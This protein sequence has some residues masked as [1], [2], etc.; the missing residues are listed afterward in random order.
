MPKA[1]WISR[2]W[3]SALVALAVLL[4]PGA[5]GAQEQDAGRAAE[6]IGPPTDF[7]EV[8]EQLS[9]GKSYA[10]VIGISEFD[11]MPYLSGVDDE[12]K[13]IVDALAAQPGFTIEPVPVGPMSKAVLK[14]TIAKFLEGKKPDD[15]LVVYIATHGYAE[16]EGKRYGYLM[17]SDSLRPGA[18]GFEN[19]AYSV[20]ELSQELNNAAPRHI[21]LF[22]NACFS[23]AMVPY[24]D[25][26][27]GA[28]P[29][30]NAVEELKGSRVVMEWMRDL[31]ALNARLVLTAGS[32]G[33]TV[34]DEKNPYAGAVADGLAGAADA[35]ADGLILGTELASFVR[36][37]VARET[38][39]KDHPNDAVFAILPKRSEAGGSG[40]GQQGD[41]V[42]LTP[43][44]A[45]DKAT[46]RPDESA[47]VL[48]ARR[49][50]LTARQFV[51]CA[52]CPVMVEVRSSRLALSRTE[53]TYTDWDACY[54]DFSCRRFLPDDG[55][56]RGD[57][58]ASGMTWQDAV[59]FE[60]WLN[61]ELPRDGMC[62][63]YRIPTRAEWLE[64]TQREPAEVGETWQLGEAVCRGCTGHDE[65]HALPVAS[66]PGDEL[67]FNDMTGNLWEWV[68]EGPACDLAVLAPNEACPGEGTVMGGSFATSAGMLSPTLEGHLPRTTNQWPWSWPTV[69]LRIA[70][71]M[72]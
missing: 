57:R 48:A 10:L 4:A 54:R 58:P 9:K 64:A 50:N 43:E 17:A 53:I 26:D 49:S 33:Q 62:E 71:D 47:Q 67:G 63:T 41:F 45:R 40:Y 16:Q 32:D 31:L 8:E 24:V 55:N 61:T 69:G 3:H 1:R 56:G 18:P 15:R 5:A 35:D 52:D 39:L 7:G 6:L 72:K 14:Q 27:R 65:G 37:R 38:R 44:G 51:D 13:L 20:S 25:T 34:P 59:Q 29:L 23:G 46:P 60:V 28:K 19:S 21:F 66:L 68:N 36:G 12:V 2:F 30:G 22:F 42:F 70:C 11:D